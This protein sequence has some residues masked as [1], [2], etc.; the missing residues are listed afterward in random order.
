M[1][2]EAYP[3][4]ALMAARAEP[5]SKAEILAKLPQ[6][7]AYLATGRSGEFLEILVD[8]GGGESK[9]YVP[10]AIGGLVLLVPAPSQAVGLDETWCPPRRF[11]RAEGFPDGAQM[12]VKAAPSRESRQITALPCGFEYTASGRVGDYLQVTLEIEG[13]IV[14][15]YVLH[16]LGGAILLEPGPGGGAATSL[17]A[18]SPQRD[19]EDQQQLRAAECAAAARAATAAATAAAAAAQAVSDVRMEALEAKVALQERQI[20]AMQAELAQMRAQLAA[21]ACALTQGVATR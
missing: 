21:A 7:F 16:R 1:C 18:A 8:L 17:V 15:A 9:V 3:A 10:Q 19:S 13:E 2:S 12:A 6:D 4:G 5:H 11:V 14:V 20:K